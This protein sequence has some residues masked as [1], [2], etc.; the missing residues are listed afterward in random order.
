[1]APG[2]A[3]R[4][5]YN[6]YDEDFD[7]SADDQAQNLHVIGPALTKD[8][9]VLSDYL[10]A[11][12]G[13]TRGT[14]SVIPILACESKPVLFTRVQ[15]RPLGVSIN[16]SPSAEKLEIIEKLMGPSTSEIIDM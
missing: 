4:Q 14:R 12:P 7:S 9:Q 3:D 6:M 8:N 15:K 10:S 1:M 16:R 11:I 13:A 5:R 2:M